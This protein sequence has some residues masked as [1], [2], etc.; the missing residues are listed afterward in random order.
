MEPERA[1]WVKVTEDEAHMV[2][3]KR[4]AGVVALDRTVCRVK[5]PERMPL[6]CVAPL[7][8]GLEAD[9]AYQ[10]MVVWYLSVVWEL[11]TALEASSF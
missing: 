3:H 2:R 7:A 5:S 6:I 8:G 11:S 4:V 9:G 1:S 10:G